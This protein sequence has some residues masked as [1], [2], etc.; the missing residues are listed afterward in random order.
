M[1]MIYWDKHIEYLVYLGEKV[2]QL[3]RWKEYGLTQMLA[4]IEKEL[5]EKEKALEK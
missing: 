3:D 4:Q 1:I 2:I 5:E